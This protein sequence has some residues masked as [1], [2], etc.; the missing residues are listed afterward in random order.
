[1][2]DARS[3]RLASLAAWIEEHL[4]ATL[5]IEALAARAAA[6]ARFSGADHLIRA[7]S[8]RFGVTPAAC[9]QI[10]GRQGLEAHAAAE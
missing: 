5:D 10:H 1:M 8:R 2:Q 4:T 7:F 6:R 3:D 9:R